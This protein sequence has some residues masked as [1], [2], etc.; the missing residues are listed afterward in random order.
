MVVFVFLCVCTHWGVRE[1]RAMDRWAGWSSHVCTYTCTQQDRGLLAA[2]VF[3]LK[4]QLAEQAAAVGV[5]GEEE[6]EG[7]KV[8]M[9]G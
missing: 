6:G 5:K 4:K 8:K 3:T 2:M 7:P 9:E 1:A